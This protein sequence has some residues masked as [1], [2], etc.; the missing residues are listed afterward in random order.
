MIFGIVNI[1]DLNCDNKIGAIS[2]TLNNCISFM[3]QG[4]LKVTIF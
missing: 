3:G 1:F 4:Y 2:I